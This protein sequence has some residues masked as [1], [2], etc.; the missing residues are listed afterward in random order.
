MAIALDGGNQHRILLPQVL[1][2]AFQPLFDGFSCSGHQGFLQFDSGMVT[3]I[4]SSIG[5]TNISESNK[6]TAD[7]NS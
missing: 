2:Q 6:L 4:V 3:G 1:F 7:T 5:S